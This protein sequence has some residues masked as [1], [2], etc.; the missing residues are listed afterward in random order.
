M[1]GIT[2]RN[3]IL[4]MLRENYSVNVT[5]LAETFGVSKETIRRDF[6]DL[7]AAGLLSRTHGG[8]YITAG[9]QND[10]NVSMRS[11]IRKK[12]KQIIAQKCVELVHTGD[13]IFLDESTTDWCIAEQLLDKHITVVTHSLKVAE[14]FSASAN[15]RVIAAGGNY[16]PRAMSFYGEQTIDDLNRYYVDK[17]F[18]SCRTV[19]MEYGATDSNENASLVR[20]T[21]LRRSGSAYLVADHT[22][23]DGISFLNICALEDVDALICD[24]PLSPAWQNHLKNIGVAYL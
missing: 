3:T 2:R 21:M 13:S 5:Q 4:E 8:A 17:A 10:I 12:E 7:E 24:Q 6:K 15:V 9:V 14:I 16:A 22:K 20:R 11:V 19:H 1:L 23:L 18:L